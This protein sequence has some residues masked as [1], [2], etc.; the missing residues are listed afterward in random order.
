MSPKS[1]MKSFIASFYLH[2]FL[3]DK[4]KCLDEMDEIAMPKSYHQGLH[5]CRLS[6]LVK[7]TPVFQNGYRTFN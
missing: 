5:H 2:Y 7:L 6:F 4:K 1:Q 3:E